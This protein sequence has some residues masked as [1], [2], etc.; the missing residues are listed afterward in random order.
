LLS[1]VNR[2]F[3]DI[4]ST[5]ASQYNGGQFEICRWADLVTA[6][7]LPGEG[8]IKGL[9]T[10]ICGINVPRGCFILAEMSCAGNLITPQYA[11][12]TH[13]SIIKKNCEL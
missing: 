2:K 5:V 4:G 12:G 11:Q 9:E 13:H 1:F 3:A 8:V 6:H 10:A 7:A